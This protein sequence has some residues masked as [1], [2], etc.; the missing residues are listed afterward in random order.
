MSSKRAKNTA[1]ILANFISRV[2]PEDISP[3]IRDLAKLH[4]LDGIATMIG[5]LG[6]GASRHIL[7]YVSASGTKKECSVIGTR[8][9][10]SAPQAALVNG[11]QGHVLDFDDSQLATLP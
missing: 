2:W 8:I 9:K 7:C 3:E 5:S 6:Q 4:L 10:V 11:V 1:E